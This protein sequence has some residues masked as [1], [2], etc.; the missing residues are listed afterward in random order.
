MYLHLPRDAT[1][2]V[3]SS[4]TAKPISSECGNGARHGGARRR[5]VNDF[6]GI[7]AQKKLL[8]ALHRTVC[9][10]IRISIVFFSCIV[11]RVY[12]FTDSDSLTVHDDGAHCVEM[13]TKASGFIST[14]PVNATRTDSKSPP[15]RSGAQ[16]PYA[17]SLAYRLRTQAHAVKEERC[18]WRTFRRQAPLLTIMFGSELQ[19]GEIIIIADEA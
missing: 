2:Q 18:C 9:I 12:S 14:K 3:R 1:G 15:G 6:G 5:N 10:F 8:K 19:R 11:S 16:V 7:Y 4:F 13:T 17:E